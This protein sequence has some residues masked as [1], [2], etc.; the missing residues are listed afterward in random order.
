M[1]GAAAS[2]QASETP[3]AND[4]QDMEPPKGRNP[5]DFR[6]FLL[7]GFIAAGIWDA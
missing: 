7:S 2:R 4:L 5:P 3:K 1:A 6:R